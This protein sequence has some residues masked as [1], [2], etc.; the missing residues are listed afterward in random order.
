M[1]CC[2][3]AYNDGKYIEKTIGSVL[4]QIYQ[5]VEIIVVADG[6]TNNKEDVS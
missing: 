1:N 6:P 3:R 2:R 4:V 5:E